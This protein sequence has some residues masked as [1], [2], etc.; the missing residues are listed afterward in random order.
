MAD[1]S[2]INI[3]DVIIKVIIGGCIA[4]FVWYLDCRRRRDAK[5]AHKKIIKMDLGK[6]NDIIQYITLNVSNI[7][8]D[9]DGTPSKLNQ[10]MARHH[11]HMESLIQDMQIQHAHCD[12]MKPHEEEMIKNAIKSARWILDNYY[13]QDI[14]EPQ[15]ERVWVEPH[16]KLHDHARTII[17]AHNGI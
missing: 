4:A 5:N 13:R 7:E 11:I 10:H 17:Q 9:V 6:I 16:D 14:P 2:E 15:R 12:K 1:L 3:I 8:E